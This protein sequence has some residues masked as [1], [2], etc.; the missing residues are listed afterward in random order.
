[1]KKLLPWIKSN[2]VSLIAVVVALIAAPVMLYFSSNWSA[3]VR[4]QVETDVSQN[5]QQLDGLDV[6]YTIN[7]YLAG[8]E[9]VSVRSAPNEA[10]I[11]AVSSLVKSVV[12][13]SGKVRDETVAFNSA[14]KTLLITGP[15]PADNLFPQ[16][17]DESTRLRLLRQLTEVWPKFH[18]DL[19]KRHR[20]ATPPDAQQV[21][22]ALE[23][24][25][26]KE[27][28]R[29]TAGRTEADLSPEDAGQLKEMLSEARLERYRR[30]AS[31][32]SMFVRGNPFL[33]VTPW[34]ALQLLPVETAWEWQFLSWV[35]QDI[36]AALARANTDTSTG[37]WQPVYRAPVKVLESIKV[38][39]ALEFS[40]NR[41][42][43][44][45]GGRDEKAAAGGVGDEGAELKP[46][47][48]LSHTGRTAAPVQPNSLFDLRYVEITLVA[49]SSQ[50]P[51]IFEAFPAV[52][53]MTVVG[54]DLEHIESV[55]LLAQGMDLGPD[56]LVRAKIRVETIWLRAWTKKHMPPSVRRSLGIPDDAPDEAPE[57]APQDEPAES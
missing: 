40:G 11:A 8:Q 23:D 48:K 56:H 7:P 50:L 44:S 49:S 27:V 14:G 52:N 46:D 43:S 30:D 22:A 47:F 51:R 24:L 38:M 9:A 16:Q 20:A 33:A 2:L 1:M 5:I 55:P 34:P 31:E 35:H 53:L 26:S 36:M 12:S 37:L 42:G 18:E 54:V 39:D 29:R 19:L 32:I 25:K 28:A 6:T 13:E 41:S 45:G 57:S 10:T 15:T 21:L 17:P 4:K 3:S